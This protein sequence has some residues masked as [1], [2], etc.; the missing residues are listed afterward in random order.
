MVLI[1]HG[2]L[3][4]IRILPVVPNEINNYLQYIKVKIK[5]ILHP[6]VASKVV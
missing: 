2:K 4:V 5:L 1:N 6:S 3:V